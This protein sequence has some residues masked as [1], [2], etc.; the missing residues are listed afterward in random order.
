MA[1][2]FFAIDALLKRSESSE[3]CF[4]VGRSY[5]IRGEGTNALSLSLSLNSA[6][7]L[8]K[9]GIQRRRL[10]IRRAPSIS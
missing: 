7:A 8:V 2:F 4:Q 10:S 6:V 3:I 5:V 9:H 1:D